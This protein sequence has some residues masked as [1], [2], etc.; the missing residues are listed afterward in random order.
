LWQ[1]R[2]STKIRWCFPFLWANL[3]MGYIPPKSSFMEKM[4]IL[5]R[6]ERG[7]LENLGHDKADL[8][9]LHLLFNWRARQ[10]WP[11]SSHLPH[12][13]IVEQDSGPKWPSISVMFDWI[14]HPRP[15]FCWLSGSPF[16]LV[17]S[18]L[19]A[20]TQVSLANPPLVAL[21]AS[22][23]RTSRH[24]A[25]HGFFTRFFRAGSCGWLWLHPQVQVPER[26]GVMSDHVEIMISRLD[27]FRICI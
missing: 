19:S 18:Q 7:F 2:V 6:K 10:R 4:M 23:T 25:R 26:H 8:F 5:Q 15:H 17:A 3:E 13:S 11:T 12:L 21:V 9:Y 16:S 22:T 24:A 20:K 27:T 1:L 14:H